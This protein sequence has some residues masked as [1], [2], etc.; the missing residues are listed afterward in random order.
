MAD[1]ATFV[2]D[3]DSTLVDFETL[4]RTPKASAHWYAELIKSRTLDAPVS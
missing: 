3:I 4:E 2:F 1:T